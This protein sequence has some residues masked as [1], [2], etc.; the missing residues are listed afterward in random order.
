M[1]AVIRNNKP[2][3]TYENPLHVFQTK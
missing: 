2:T 3:K 1:Y